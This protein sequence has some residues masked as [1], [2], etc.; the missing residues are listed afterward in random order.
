MGIS[1]PGL[2]ESLSRAAFDAFNCCTSARVTDQIYCQNETK[3][4]NEDQEKNRAWSKP[5]L[6]LEG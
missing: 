5:L 3:V 4:A 2:C 1:S 6:N